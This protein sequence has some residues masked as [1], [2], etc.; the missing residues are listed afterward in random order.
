MGKAIAYLFGV[1]CGVAVTIF[2]GDRLHIIDPIRSAEANGLAVRIESIETADICAALFADAPLP[3]QDH[4]TAWTDGTRYLIGGW[5]VE[6][7]MPHFY[8]RGADL[9]AD[10]PGC[11]K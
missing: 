5:I 9:P 10:E 2:I 1:I 8:W 4:V 3:A 11:R 7:G 6:D